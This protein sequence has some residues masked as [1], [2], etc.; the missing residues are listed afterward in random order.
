M[1]ILPASCIS[2]PHA[3]RGGKPWKPQDLMGHHFFVVRAIADA[4]DGSETGEQAQDRIAKEFFA[5]AE[6][7][8]A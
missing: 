3:G 8:D 2:R 1:T 4:A 7:W 6:D 5:A